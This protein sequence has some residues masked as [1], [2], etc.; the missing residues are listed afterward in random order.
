MPANPQACGAIE[1][2]GRAMRSS[3]NAPAH[4]VR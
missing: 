4:S 2:L 3:L 1:T